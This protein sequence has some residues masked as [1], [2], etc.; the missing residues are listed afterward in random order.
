MKKLICA[1]LIIT[2]IF[3]GSASAELASV[4]DLVTLRDQ[5]LGA[6]ATNT[7]L[8]AIKPETADT[9]SAAN[10]NAAALE[11]ANKVESEI[12]SPRS[13]S[14]A[15]NIRVMFVTPFKYK[16]V[17]NILIRKSFNDVQKSYALEPGSEKNDYVSFEKTAKAILDSI[18][19]C[20]LPGSVADRLQECANKLPDEFVMATNLIHSYQ[21][22]KDVEI[23]T[24]LGLYADKWKSP[25]LADRLQARLLSSCMHKALSDTSDSGAS[26]ET[27]RQAANWDLRD[28]FTGFNDA[29]C[30]G[31]SMPTKT[32]SVFDYRD[33]VKGCV[34][35]N[36]IATAS[37]GTQ[38]A[39]DL[40]PTIKI[41]VQ[42]VKGGGSVQVVLQPPLIASSALYSAVYMRLIGTEDA[43]G[44]LK[45]D[46]FL[47][48]ST[49]GRIPSIFAPANV[50]YDNKNMQY[51]SIGIPPTLITKLNALPLGDREFFI[52]MLARKLTLIQSLEIIRGAQMIAIESDR[53]LNSSDTDLGRLTATVVE[54]F[55]IM[56][57]SYNESIDLT[58]TLTIEDILLAVDNLYQNYMEAQRKHGSSVAVLQNEVHRQMVDKS[59]GK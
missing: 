9:T 19:K 29:A 8:D 39:V 15:S 11:R 52:E 34:A 22:W 55:D 37:T 21:A 4:N 7:A 44:I 12:T 51:F 17:G 50:S 24:I 46:W 14:D 59:L 41:A 10:A 47:S 3:G 53:A 23:R 30:S 36:K 45:S 35:N 20:Q 31:G 28:L 48:G 49:Q 18:G 57:R 27:C 54:Y 25:V 42:T 26:I 13:A 16:N 5:L 2:G 6:K 58:S 1:G 43:P 38:L 33:F 56:A 32:K 40:F